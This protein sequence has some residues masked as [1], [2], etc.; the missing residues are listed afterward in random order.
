MILDFSSIQAIFYWS[1]FRF[2]LHWWLLEE[3]LRNADGVFLY[4]HTDKTVQLW[5]YGK[6]KI[7]EEGLYEKIIR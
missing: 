3:P 1:W 5:N 4:A 6:K 2:K 7:L